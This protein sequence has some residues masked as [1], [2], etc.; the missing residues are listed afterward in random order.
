MS[1]RAWGIEPAEQALDYPCDRHIA[2]P[3]DAWYRGVDVAAPVSLVYRWLCQLRI[4]PYSYDLLDNFARRSPQELVPGLD[5]LQV[6][7]RVMH[8]FELAEFE[9]DRHLT[10]CVR[11]ARAVFMHTAVSY[12]VRPAPDGEGTRLLVK[13]AFRFPRLPLLRPALRLVLPLADTIMMRR[14]L[15][16]LRRLAERDA[17]RAGSAAA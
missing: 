8:V 9:R 11:R 4:S 1:L 10:A 16:N 13:V 6:G 15:A 14:Q 17:A 2:D 7:Q 12:V 3:D 5:E